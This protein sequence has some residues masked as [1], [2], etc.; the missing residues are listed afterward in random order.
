MKASIARPLW[1]KMIKNQWFFLLI[2]VIVL[3]IIT[4]SVNS[5]FFSTRNIISILEQIS[6]LGLV[7]SGAT[8]LII[9]GNFDISVGA[10]IGLGSCVTA[11]LIIQDLPGGSREFTTLSLIFPYVS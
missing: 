3:S 5:K 8:I 2:V 7:A 10:M 1:Q 11:M 6:V 4:G 9:S